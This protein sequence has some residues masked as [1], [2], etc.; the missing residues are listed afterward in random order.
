MPIL[1]VG[2]SGDYATPCAAIAAAA[3]GDTIEVDAAGDYDGDT[4]AWSTDNLTIRGVNGRARIDATGVALAEQKGIFVIHADRATIESF[5]LSGASV[6]DQNGAGI[7]H[8]GLDLVV[9]DCYFH[10]DEDGI[11]G[12]PS[13]DGSGTV[14]IQRSEFAHNGYG[15][16]YSHNLY[17][18]HYAKVTV[19]E[20]YSHDAVVGHL[21]KSRALTNYILY[22]RL[23]DEGGTASYELDLPN[24]GRSYVIG[25]VIEQAATADNSSIVAYGEEPDGINPDTHLFFVNNTVL[26]DRSAGTF[27]NIGTSVTEPVVVTNDVFA[28]VGTVSTQTSTVVTRSWDASMGDPSFVDAGT[29]DL[30]LADGSPCIDAG[31]DPGSDGDYSLSPDAQYVH[32]TSSE[33]RGIGGDAIDIGAFEY[34]NP[35]LAAGDDTGGGGEETGT[36]GGPSGKGCG[37][38]SAPRGTVGWIGAFLV[39]L[40]A[41]RRARPAQSRP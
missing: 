11:L 7:R 36:N 8:Q 17:L 24:A 18:N 31:T 40:A 21:L 41:R 29:F 38:D 25:N 30:A 20:S 22:N 2:P 1:S 19:R 14:L 3:A 16:G 37:C 10:D 35:G 12:A 28:G 26:N 33:P 4:C 6:P 15:D 23:T 5:E 13:T 34:R 27:L 9:S 32:P 39:A